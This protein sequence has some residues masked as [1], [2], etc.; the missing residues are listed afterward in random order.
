[1]SKDILHF[2][3]HYEYIGIFL[4]LAFGLIGLPV[5]DEILLTFS[6]YLVYKGHTEFALTL[7]SAFLGAM[8]GISISYFLGYKLGLPF[9][10]KFG[11]KVGISENKIVKTQ[12]YFQKYGNIMILVGYFIPGIRHISAYIAGISAMKFKRFALYAYSGG[13]I[14]SLTFILLGKALGKKWRV[15]EQYFQHLGLYAVLALIAVILIVWLI[16][17]FKKRPTKS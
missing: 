1:M 2:I 15:V 3:I 14:W 13:L 10:R 16:F 8:S 12:G 6:G 5:P 7:L 17:K 9:L 4:A 11:P